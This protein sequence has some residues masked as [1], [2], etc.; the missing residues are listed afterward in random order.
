MSLRDIK[1]G[2]NRLNNINMT[3]A[4]R[5]EKK[6]KRKSSYDLFKEKIEFLNANVDKARVYIKP[7]LNLRHEEYNEREIEKK[8]EFLTECE[9]KLESAV[10]SKTLNEYWEKE[11]ART[12]RLKEEYSKEVEEYNESLERLDKL[13]AY[14]FSTKFKPILEKQGEDVALAFNLFNSEMDLYNGGEL[15]TLKEVIKNRK[16]VIKGLEED[17]EDLEKESG[18][19]RYFLLEEISIKEIEDTGYYGRLYV[20]VKDEV[21][22]EC[23]DL[24]EVTKKE[25]KEYIED[26]WEEDCEGFYLKKTLIEWDEKEHITPW[27]AFEYK[28]INKELSF[29]LKK[30]RAMIQW[31]DEEAYGDRFTIYFNDLNTPITMVSPGKKKD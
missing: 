31:E 9:Q 5:I 10:S 26:G 19:D 13:T 21:L 3:I 11:E 15:A 2:L 22:T 7:L 23:E 16:K 29:E 12:L 25:L 8:T 30:G 17:I 20:R 28:E 14:E 24:N 27:G 6:K 18:D 1:Q 4:E